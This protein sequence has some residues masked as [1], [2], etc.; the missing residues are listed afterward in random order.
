MGE[1]KGR[2]GFSTEWGGSA[3]LS[4]GVV[5]E[6]TLLQIS[7]IFHR[8]LQYGT[9][10]TKGTGGKETLRNA[11]MHTIHAWHGFPVH[12][13]LKSNFQF[14]KKKEKTGMSLYTFIFIHIYVHI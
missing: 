13:E 12:V 4:P 9:Q 7:P 6:S 10:Y 14:K 11:A 2:H 8:H 1:S 5:Q 3:T